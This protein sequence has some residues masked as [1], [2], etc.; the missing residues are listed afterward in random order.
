MAQVRVPL[1]RL[2]LGMPQQAL[3]LVQA[4]P[5]V[6]QKAGIAVPQVVDADISQAGFGS[7]RIPSAKDRHIGL[8]CLWV[9]KHPLTVESRDRPKQA[10]HAIGHRHKAGLTQFG[11]VDAPM[12]ALEVKVFPAGVQHLALSGTRQD[13]H[14]HDVPKHLVV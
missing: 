14:G 10:N 4:A 8:E 12:P 5:R 6:D 3:H 9:S 11:G 2:D 1:R 13:Q 7:G